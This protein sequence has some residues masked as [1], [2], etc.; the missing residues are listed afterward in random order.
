MQVYALLALLPILQK[1]LSSHSMGVHQLS[2][3]S[4]NPV[5]P[6]A[7]WLG[8][9]WAHRPAALA[10]AL[11]LA[12]QPCPEEAHSHHMGQHQALNE[13]T[14]AAHADV[15]PMHLHVVPVEIDGIRHRG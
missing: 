8:T 6:D 3:P 13:P 7:H 2:R 4:V 14:L 1:A 5:I 11:L 9:Y 15:G 12:E 10:D